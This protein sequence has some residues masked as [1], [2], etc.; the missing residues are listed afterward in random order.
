MTVRKDEMNNPEVIRRPSVGMISFFC[1]SFFFRSLFFFV[2]HAQHVQYACRTTQLCLNNISRF[3]FFLF[4]PNRRW[5]I[6]VV[7]LVLLPFSISFSSILFYICQNREREKQLFFCF[8]TIEQLSSS[9]I[10]LL[11]YLIN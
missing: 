7:F 10:C 2:V 9:A 6:E 11:V 4:E 1:L 5:M 3:S 8:H